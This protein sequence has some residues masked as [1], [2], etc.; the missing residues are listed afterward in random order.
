MHTIQLIQIDQIGFDET[1]SR[2]VP[3]E[4]D[5]KDE[6]L[7]SSIEGTGLIHEIIV[8][9]R[10]EDSP[11]KEPYILVVGSRR[12]SAM[13][14]SGI[15]EV[16]CKVIELTDVEAVGISLNENLGRRELSTLEKVRSIRTWYGLLNLSDQEAVEEIAKGTYGNTSSGRSRVR[17]YLEAAKLPEGL[18]VLLKDPDKRTK[19]EIKL[20]KDHGISKDY[21]IAIQTVGVVLGDVI[22]VLGDLSDSEKTDKVLTIIGTLKLDESTAEEQQ[23]VLRI[24]H[25]KLEEGK[26]LSVIMG[27]LKEEERKLRIRQATGFKIVIPAKYEDWHRKA[28]ASARAKNA[29]L[30]IRR[31]YIDYLKNRAEE[32]GWK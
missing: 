29:R 28:M 31:I 23:R 1:Q 26:L 10:S 25:K 14:Q 20:L 30:F 2:L 7:Q 16:P 24:I 19:K 3:W 17:Y 5:E 9:P 32:E 8:R 27:E 15:S 11:V 4:G 13:I 21:K 6:T 12:F 22:G 18:M